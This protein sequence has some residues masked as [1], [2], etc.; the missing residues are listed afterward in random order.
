MNFTMRK[1][2]QEQ[3]GIPGW[4][5]HPD[6]PGRHPGVMM[7]YHAPGLTGDY[8]FHAATLARRGYCVLV[9]SVYNML[10]VPGDHHHGMGAEIQAKHGDADFLR[11]MDAAWQWFKARPYA[12][13]ARL[14][15][16]GHCMG[17]RLGMPF[18]ADH[19]DLAALVL[20]Y[21]TIRDEERTPM[22]PRHSFDTAKLVKCPTLVFYGGNDYLT[23]NAIQ[24][25]LWQ[26]FL[27]GGAPL[28]WHFFSEGT[29]G[30]A[31]HD[32]D[33]Y[34]PRFADLTPPLLV[35]FLDRRL[36]R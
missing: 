31:S 28:E 1:L 19:P 30:F 25:K 32:S 11:V 36:G 35:D 18:A 34:Q 24:L 17:G 4:I 12:D 23:P 33:Q 27:E 29:H 21:A 9:P 6:A 15:Y 3:D 16:L 20:F 8:K 5:A 2:T 14:A 26:A 22:R 13:P 10:G 7:I